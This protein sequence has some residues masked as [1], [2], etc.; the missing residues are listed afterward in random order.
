LFPVNAPSS[1]RLQKVLPTEAGPIGP[2]KFFKHLDGS[3]IE[4][5]DR[6]ERD[7]FLIKFDG[8]CF[9]QHPCQLVF[10]TPNIG[11]ASPEEGIRWV[12]ADV[13]R[14]D[15]SRSRRDLDD[16]ERDVALVHSSDAPAISDVIADP[17]L[18][19]QRNS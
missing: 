7:D 9:G 4:V 5:I 1:D 16:Y 2:H 14:S 11:L 18:V 15:V 12:V 13:H 10:C 6:Q 3:G 8:G 19:S 17:L